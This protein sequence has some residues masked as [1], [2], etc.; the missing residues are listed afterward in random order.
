MSKITVYTAG[1]LRRSEEGRTRFFVAEIHHELSHLV[2]GLEQIMKNYPLTPDHM[3][4]F[5]TAEII[6]TY[7]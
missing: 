2:A 7:S 5:I 1:L 6:N 4:T 3:G